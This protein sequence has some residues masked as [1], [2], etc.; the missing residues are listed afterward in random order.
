MLFFLRML[1]LCCFTIATGVVTYTFGAFYT[2][3][4]FEVS[5]FADFIGGRSNSFFI[6]FVF[7]KIEVSWR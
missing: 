3:F 4:L 6:D 1:K 2:G 7:S 5:F